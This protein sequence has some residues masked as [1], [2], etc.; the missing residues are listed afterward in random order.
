MKNSTDE[1][2]AKTNAGLS[3]PN[4]KNA[5]STGFYNCHTHIFNFDHVHKNFLKGMAP[6]WIGFIGIVI[7][8]A[9]FILIIVQFCP[10]QIKN[11]I[12]NNLILPDGFVPK[13]VLWLIV[14]LVFLLLS[15]FVVLLTFVP[16]NIHKFLQRNNRAKRVT[17]LLKIMIPGDF[18]FLERYANFILHAYDVNRNKSKTQEDVF[19]ELQS[20]YPSGTKF[21]VLSMDMDYMVD[22]TKKENDSTFPG[23]LTALKSLK[24]NEKYKQVIFPFIHADPRRLAKD[25]KYFDELKVDI[26]DGRFSGIKIYPALGYFP[27]DIRLKPVY[28]LALKYDLPI[29]T[30]CSVGPVYYRGHLNTLEK[31]G[32]FD[33]KDF[34]H[35]FTCKKLYGKSP[36]DF[37]PH[38][39]HPLNYFFLMNNPKELSRFWEKCL[40]TKKNDLSHLSIGDCSEG[41][42][43]QYSNLKICFGHFG[44]S[45]EWRR[46]LDNA[47]QAKER[48]DLRQPDNFARLYHGKKGMWKLLPNTNGAS[49][50]ELKNLKALNWFS[51]I[52]DMLKFKDESG[53]DRFPNLY[54]DIS[55]NLSDQK[56][57]PLLKVRLETDDQIRRKILF[58]TDFYMVSMK[59]TERRATINLRSFIGEDS[60]YQIAVA[61]PRAFLHNRVF[62][63]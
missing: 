8:V 20:Y 56:M 29:T 2:A 37:S 53:N 22:C 49:N 40:S 60:F 31:D 21:V 7:F 24:N 50:S 6:K 15:V 47:W 62:T 32:Y 46:Y 35:P 44:G 9:A 27:F 26:K 12:P 13:R 25:E 45:E 14:F 3:S 33:D 48:I 4:A 52:S 38:F 39:T 54:A 18:D 55:Y 63:P 34:M 16:V 10:A 61:N 36:K 17:S 59:M 41:F 51:I 1:R 19:N 43:K 5:D 28:D 30:H 57:M 23:Q 42:L 58:G 11:H